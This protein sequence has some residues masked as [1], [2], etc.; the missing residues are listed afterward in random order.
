MKYRKQIRRRQSYRYYRYHG[1]GGDPKLYSPNTITNIKNAISSGKSNRS[2][3]HLSDF[4]SSW[5]AGI[6]QNA[7]Q[8]KHRIDPTRIDIENRPP[9]TRIATPSRRI[10]TP[11]R[12]IA[13]PS[14]RTAT[15]SRS[16]FASK[17]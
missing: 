10:A 15:P 7:L 13:T 14:R 4:T 1:V 11:S 5:R 2:Y 12:K 6:A 16:K 8:L 17:S 3:P 9:I